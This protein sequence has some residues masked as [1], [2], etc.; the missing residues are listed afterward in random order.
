M[1]SGSLNTNTINITNKKPNTLRI[2]Y[3][4]LIL[5]PSET[6]TTSIALYPIIR[7]QTYF[8]TR[9]TIVLQAKLITTKSTNFKEHLKYIKTT[10]N[11]FG[12]YKGF[13]PYCLLSVCEIIPFLPLSFIMKKFN[14]NK[15]N[16]KIM[17]NFYNSCTCFIYA[18]LFYPLEIL[19]IK[20]ASSYNTNFNKNDTGGI[21]LLIK[22]RFA[23]KNYKGFLLCGLSYSIKYYTLDNIIKANLLELI[24]CTAISVI[25]DNIR[26]NYCLSI[27]DSSL[28]YTSY[29]F[30]GSS[31]YLPIFIFYG[32]IL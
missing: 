1:N 7:L 13:I 15:E 4:Y 12:L 21:D 11:L 25:I 2:L 29:L 9:S 28:N 10:G 14:I 22:D 6:F 18:G 5:R 27:F 31:F 32:L 26:R 16:N 19:Q 30:R 8:Q 3:N 23:K 20:M 17:Y 24:F